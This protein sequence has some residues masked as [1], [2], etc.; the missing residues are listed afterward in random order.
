ML[1]SA[2]MESQDHFAQS[3]KRKVNFSYS[4]KLMAEQSYQADNPQFYVETCQLILQLQH[5][6][7][8]DSSET[9]FDYGMFLFG[10]ENFLEAKNAL[11][12]AIKGFDTHGLSTHSSFLGQCHFQ[13][14]VID[15]HLGHF[16]E[17]VKCFQKACKFKIMDGNTKMSSA[18]CHHWQGYVYRRMEDFNK[19]LEAQKRALKEMEQNTTNDS[20]RRFLGDVYL[21]LGCIRQKRA[22]KEMEQNTTNDSSRRFLGDVYLELGCI[23]HEF[24]NI[25]NAA[26]FLEKCLSIHEEQVGYFKPKLQLYIHLAQ[27]LHEKSIKCSESIDEWT[28]RTLSLLEKAV[29]LCLENSHNGHFH[30]KFPVVMFAHTDRI[31]KLEDILPLTLKLCSSLSSVFD[32]ENETAKKRL[33]NIQKDFEYLLNTLVK[34]V[35]Q[36]QHPNSLDDGSNRSVLVIK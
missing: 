27:V 22:L 25:E 3:R 23:H 12:N 19:A 31:E 14:G 18:I 32:E 4:L 13:V 36:D 29:T 10:K 9:W 6:L 34:S 33:K 1:Q 8:I 21:E 26:S 11:E 28:Q 24:G 20:S 5:L 7:K 15:S 16:S 35:H 2:R 30:D 17:A